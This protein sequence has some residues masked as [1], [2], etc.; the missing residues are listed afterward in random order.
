M[1]TA[2]RRG[3]IPWL[4]ERLGK[5][6]VVQVEAEQ[7]ETKTTGTI[8]GFVRQVRAFDEQLEAATGNSF[9][10]VLG[11]VR[12]TGYTD[13]IEVPSKYVV[14]VA[15]V[16]DVKRVNAEGVLEPIPSVLPPPV[17]PPAVPASPADLGALGKHGPQGTDSD[18]PKDVLGENLCHGMGSDR[19]A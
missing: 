12:T 14:A 11:Q 10:L 7:F 16:E 19:G 13:G 6:V 5:E 18:R 1:G 15:D 17:P 8:Q 4:V 3:M 9:G 2:S